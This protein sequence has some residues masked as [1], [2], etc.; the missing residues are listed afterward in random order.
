MQAPQRV[1]PVRAG[2]VAAEVRVGHRFAGSPKYTP[3]GVRVNE[4]SV[5]K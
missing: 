5:P 3:Q 2:P 1:Q 4:S